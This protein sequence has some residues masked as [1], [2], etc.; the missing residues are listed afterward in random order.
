LDGGK[1]INGDAAYARQEGNVRKNTTSLTPKRY[2]REKEREKRKYFNT[3]SV[4]LRVRNS[5][6]C[7]LNVSGIRETRAC[8]PWK[9]EKLTH[10]QGEG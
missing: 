6:R 8:L 4:Y 7:L 3:E 5:H 9:R 10:G 2:Q 1:D